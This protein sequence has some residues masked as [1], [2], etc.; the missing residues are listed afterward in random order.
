MDYDTRQKL[1]SLLKQEPALFERVDLKVC[2][3]GIN[4][5]EDEEASW[6]TIDEDMKTDSLQTYRFCWSDV[7]AFGIHP[8][9]AIHL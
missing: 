9:T 2:S 5:L 4:C 6:I 1:A 8:P 3:G 7:E